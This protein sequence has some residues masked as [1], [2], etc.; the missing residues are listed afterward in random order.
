MNLKCFWLLLIPLMW[1]YY[2]TLDIQWKVKV[3][4][5]IH[6]VYLF[7]SEVQYFEPNLYLCPMDN[8]LCYYINIDTSKQI[9]L[10]FWNMIKFSSMLKWISCGIE[11]IM[12]QSNWTAY[13][14]IVFLHIFEVSNAFFMNFPSN[15]FLG[16]QK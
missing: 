11:Y 5:G 3:N 15:N 16:N 2:L 14:S 10:R 8:H 6:C 4:K 7:C 9:Y 12:G 1:D 13:I